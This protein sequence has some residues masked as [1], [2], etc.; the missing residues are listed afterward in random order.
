M[1]ILPNKKTPNTFNSLMAF[2]R[3]ALCFIRLFLKLKKPIQ[4][5]RFKICF[6]SMA[7]EHKPFARVMDLTGL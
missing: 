1:K 3:F 2:T 6:N 7:Y 5:I 4:F